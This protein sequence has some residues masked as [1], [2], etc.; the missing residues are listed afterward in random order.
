MGGSS[1]VEIRRVKVD[2]E[3]DHVP[4]VRVEGDVTIV[5]VVEEVLV[6]EKRLV[7]KEEVH[8]SK[9]IFNEEAEVTV[10]VRK[11]RV[12]IGREIANDTLDQKGRDDD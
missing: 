9:R 5:P 3:V 10:P 4:K 2:R 12:I 6:V 8:I 11:Q 7:L 1:E